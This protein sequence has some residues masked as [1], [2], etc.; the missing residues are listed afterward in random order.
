MATKLS[1]LNN[2]EIAILEPK[3]SLIGGDE[4]D[5]LKSKAKDLIEQG[6]KKLVLDLGGVTYINSSGIGALVAI[7]SMYKK[8]SG[9]IK[10]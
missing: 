8:A 2:L 3:G 7:H 1:T 10:L 5:E 6:N 4:T 9:Q